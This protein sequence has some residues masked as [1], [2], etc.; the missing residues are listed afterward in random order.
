MAQKA[1]DGA[2]L[3][4]PRTPFGMAGIV[5]EEGARGKQMPHPQKARV[6]NDKLCGHGRD[7]VE[8]C[9]TPTKADP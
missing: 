1:C 7:G 8:Q 9:S 3:L 4:T 2:E 5:G 6:R